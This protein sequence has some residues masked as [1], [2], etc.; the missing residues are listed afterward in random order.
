M[1]HNLLHPDDPRRA[2]NRHV[3]AA[4]FTDPQIAS[5]GLRTRTRATAASRYVAKIQD[6][7]DVA[8]GWAMEDTTGFVQGRRRRRT[9]RCSARTS[10]A[11]RRPR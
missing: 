6:Y 8:Y 1:R 11:R 7:G 9:G 4:V 2:D 5:V 3:P 10:W